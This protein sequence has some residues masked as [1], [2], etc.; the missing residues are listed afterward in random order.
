MCAHPTLCRIKTSKKVDD[1][2]FSGLDECTR[3]TAETTT[4][5]PRQDSLT[6]SSG[7]PIAPTQRMNVRPWFGSAVLACSIHSFLGEGDKQPVE[8]LADEDRTTRQRRR[9]ADERNDRFWRIVLKKSKM[10]KGRSN[11]QTKPG[12]I[13]FHTKLIS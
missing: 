5:Y 13:G 10:K 1:P 8:L 11:P 3:E 7:R 6:R 2:V 9:R 12:L 4:G